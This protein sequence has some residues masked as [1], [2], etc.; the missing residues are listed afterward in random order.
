MHDFPVEANF[1]EKNSLLNS[2]SCDHSPVASG[3]LQHVHPVGQW[4]MKIVTTADDSGFPVQVSRHQSAF[5]G[6]ANLQDTLYGEDGVGFPMLAWAEREEGVPFFW[7]EEQVDE[8]FVEGCHEGGIR[9][10]RNPLS[11]M[12]TDT[13]FFEISGSALMGFD[14]EASLHQIVLPPGVADTLINSEGY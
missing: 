8:V 7:Q 5:L 13:V 2:Q 14:Y 9:L 6:A 12:Q 1:S 11:S 3:K 4:Q 10:S